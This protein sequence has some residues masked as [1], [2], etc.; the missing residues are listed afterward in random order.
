[1][2]V[3]EAQHRRADYFSRLL[4]VVRCISLHERL[5]AAK[6]AQGLGGVKGIDV[7]TSDAGVLRVDCIV[8]CTS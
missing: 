8:W 1:M 2:R 3:N 7:D 5:A 4:G 6:H